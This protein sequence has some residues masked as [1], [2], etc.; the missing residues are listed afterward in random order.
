MRGR[1]E[2][3]PHGARLH[4]APGVHHGDAIAGSGHDAQVVRDED[5]CEAVLLLQLLEQP[6]VLRLDREIE[7]R[8]RL[9]GDQHPRRSRHGDG[10]DDALS[11]AAGQLMRIGVQPRGG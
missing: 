2:D 9:V 11:H 1:A 10:A 4:D 5:H 3:A 8:G 7:A 6:E